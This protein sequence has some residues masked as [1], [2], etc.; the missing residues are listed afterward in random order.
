MAEKFIFFRLELLHSS[1][2]AADCPMSNP[3]IVNANVMRS[4]YCSFTAQLF[5]IR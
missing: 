4:C 2:T 1:I 3:T 5:E